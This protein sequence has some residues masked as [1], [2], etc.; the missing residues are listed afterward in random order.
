MRT[1]QI[2]SSISSLHSSARGVHEPFT[3]QYIPTNIRTR[4]QFLRAPR[5]PQ[6]QKSVTH[7]HKKISQFTGPSHM[8][9]RILVEVALDAVVFAYCVYSSPIHTTNTH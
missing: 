9:P 1:L 2:V 7:I 6:S 5:N 8:P 4:S 3:H